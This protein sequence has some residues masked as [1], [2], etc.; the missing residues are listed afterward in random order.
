[1]TNAHVTHVSGDDWAGVYVNGQLFEADHSIH[2]SVIG[3]IVAWKGVITSYQSF[4]VAPEWL[5]EEGQ[6]PPYLNLIPDEVRF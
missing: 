5:E 4:Q 3:E 1:M 6:L 2:F